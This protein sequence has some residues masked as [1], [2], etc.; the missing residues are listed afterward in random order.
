M[1]NNTDN[2]DDQITLD[3]IDEVVYSTMLYERKDKTMENHLVINTVNNRHHE[4]L[5]L[6]NTVLEKD[7]RGGRY[8]KDNL[9]H[10][11]DPTDE[12]KEQIATSLYFG[13]PDE[14][15]YERMRNDI[16]EYHDSL[17]GEKS[18]KLTKMIDDYNRTV[19]AERFKNKTF[20]KDIKF[21]KLEDLQNST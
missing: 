12:L 5:K 20:P 18:D 6:L 4:T 10:Y 1:E 21:I 16:Q 13:L 3:D 7:K 9:W 17:S 14:W 2:I 19:G 8:D 11:N 15:K